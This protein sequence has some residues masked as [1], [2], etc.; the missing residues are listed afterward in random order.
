MTDVGRRVDD[1]G[2][3]KAEHGDFGDALGS[4]LQC[5]GTG[6]IR[7]N[8]AA[9]ERTAAMP[10]LECTLGGTMTLVWGWSAV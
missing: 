8:T 1:E 5:Q 4:L 9:P 10:P 6:R 2:G 7:P 3:G